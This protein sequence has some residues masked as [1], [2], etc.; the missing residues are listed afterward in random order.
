V[1]AGTVG[2]D[3]VPIIPIPIGGQVWR[4]VIDTGFNGD[5]EL[6]EALRSILDARFIGRTR[7]LLAAGQTAVE[8]TFLVNFP[9]DGETVLAEATFS[10]ASEI[11]M[12]TGMLKR[13]RLQIHFPNRTV[14]L[15]TMT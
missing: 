8:D 11:L 4:A 7:F 12:G 10:P 1:I 15:E 14:T 9:F 13:H 2:T 6:P 5:L 3:G